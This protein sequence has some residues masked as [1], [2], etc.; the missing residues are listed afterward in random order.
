MDFY[1]PIFIAYRFVVNYFLTY[2]FSYWFSL[3]IFLK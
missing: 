2:Y 3:N 1:A